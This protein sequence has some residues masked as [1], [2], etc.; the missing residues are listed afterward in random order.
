MKVECKFTDNRHIYK[1]NQAYQIKQ[2][3]V[4]QDQFRGNKYAK[5]ITLYINNSQGIDLADMKNNM[6]LW[7]K[8][9]TQEAEA[10]QRVVIIDLTLPVTA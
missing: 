5:E 1:F 6:A 10:G 2:L 9:K 3:M 7:K 4:N 8:V